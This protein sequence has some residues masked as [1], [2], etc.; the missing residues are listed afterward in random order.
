MIAGN[1]RRINNVNLVMLCVDL[2]INV[3]MGICVNSIILNYR[4][5][6][7]GLPGTPHPDQLIPAPANLV[8]LT[9]S[10]A[11]TVP[12]ALKNNQANAHSIT[13]FPHSLPAHFPNQ[14]KEP[15][16]NADTVHP[17]TNTS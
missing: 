16:N 7:V 14:N 4:A 11:N 6:S 17:A 3:M 5:R 2:G 13:I 9:P 1:T 15:N 8:P 12:N 10:P